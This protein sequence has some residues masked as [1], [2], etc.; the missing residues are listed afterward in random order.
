MMAFFLATP[1]GRALANKL[2]HYFV[3]A[4]ELSFPIPT[5]WVT[6]AAQYIEPTTAPTA[7]ITVE[8][9]TQPS[10]EVTVQGKLVETSPTLMRQIQE[11]ETDLGFQ[12]KVLPPHQAQLVVEDLI[13]DPI[14]MTVYIVYTNP[15]GVEVG[16]RQGI[17]EFP[18]ENER[19]QEVPES[20][21]LPAQVGEY[22]AEFVR[23]MFA[24]TP[25]SEALSWWADAP[26]LRLRWKE[27]DR[28]FEIS[29]TGHP[30]MSP[31][32]EKEDLIVL[33]EHLVIASLGNG[34]ATISGAPVELDAIKE[35]AA[36]EIRI[37]TQLPGDFFFRYAQ[38]DDQ[39]QCVVLVYSTE[40]RDGARGFLV[41]FETPQGDTNRVYGVGK[42]I[43]IPIG[44]ATG[45]YIVGYNT[46]E[47]SPYRPAERMTW[48]EDNITIEIF[49]FASVILGYN[50][51]LGEDGM[52]EIA[53][54]MR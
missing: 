1:Q 31:P 21:I 2:L 35:Q 19:W 11:S 30:E 52:L 50:N 6:D 46:G 47:P 22:P 42:I 37:P 9:V 4:H 25:D 23:G 16:L 26:F 33:A 34:E 53:E 39:A 18:P 43:S 40:P 38:Y 7:Y 49:H 15:Y 45:Q 27:G 5:Q 28:W 12:I 32:L 3:S 14:L 36:F 44:E 10:V 41:I 24:G 48:Q 17:G 8:A 51:R 13:L 29:R 54:S 20:A